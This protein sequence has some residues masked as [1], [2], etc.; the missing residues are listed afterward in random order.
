MRKIT[1]WKHLF[2]LKESWLTILDQDYSILGDL[3]QVK[4]GPIDGLI[5]DFCWAL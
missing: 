3:K 4:K 1:L 2:S 5:S